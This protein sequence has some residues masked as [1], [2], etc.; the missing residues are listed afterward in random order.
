[1]A[2]T[3]RLLAIIAV[4][5]AADLVRGDVLAA[6]TIGASLEITVRSADDLR[7]LAGARVSIEG[8]GIQALTDRNGFARILDMPAGSRAVEVQYLGY[9]SVSEVLSFDPGKRTTVQYRLQVRPVEL[10]EVRVRVRSDILRTRGFYDRQ[11][12]GQG[13]FLTRDDIDRNRPRYM[14]DILRRISGIQV[15]AGSPRPTAEIRSPGRSCPIQYFLDGALT[16]YFNID[17]VLPH[18]VEGLEIYRGAS[19][20]PPAY[21]KGTSVCGVILIWTRVD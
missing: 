19:T 13:T 4:L 6:Q 17:E 5:L 9:E 3:A 10:A 20:V 2:P 15:G 12:G 7:P 14:S 16:A 8:L 21:N 11:R 1:M 18:D